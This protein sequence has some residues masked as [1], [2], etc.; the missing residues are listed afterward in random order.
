MFKN[1]VKGL[2]SMKKGGKVQLAVGNERI[3][4]SKNYF[5]GFE[6]PWRKDLNKIDNVS[7][8]KRDSILK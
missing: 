8:S 5:V 4:F 2:S 3:N 6:M 7:I 1:L